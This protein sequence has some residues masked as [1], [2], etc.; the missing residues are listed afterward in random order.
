VRVGAA[1]R[2]ATAL[3]TRRNSCQIVPPRPSCAV[4]GGLNR[5]KG[6]PFAKI[7]ISAP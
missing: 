4:F 3:A 1:L 7:K 2:R 6:F 5:A